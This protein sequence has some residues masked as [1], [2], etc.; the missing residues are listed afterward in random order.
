MDG[1]VKLGPS[2]NETSS[3]LKVIIRVSD[4]GSDRFQKQDRGK[5]VSR[6]RSLAV[7]NGIIA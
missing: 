4:V 5:I 1:V 2:L 7:T 6:Q 3:Y